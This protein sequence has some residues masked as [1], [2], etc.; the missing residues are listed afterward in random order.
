MNEKETFYPINAGK[1]DKCGYYKTWGFKVRNPKTGKMMPG[2]VTEDGIKIG[3][4]ECPYY[5]NRNTTSF[6][7]AELDDP[8]DTAHHSGTWMC[9][10]GETRCILVV[11]HGAGSPNGCILTLNDALSN[12]EKVG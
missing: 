10:C 5:A 8:V 2:H 4:G 3:N 1:C 7:P 9:N 6:P 12:W 11:M